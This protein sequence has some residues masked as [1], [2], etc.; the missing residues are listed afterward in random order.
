[1][2]L[3]HTILDIFAHPG[4]ITP[5]GAKSTMGATTRTIYGSFEPQQPSFL[6]VPQPS[7]SRTQQPSAAV[8]AA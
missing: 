7:A 5:M 3:N 2:Q 4:A 6:T 8:A 1:M